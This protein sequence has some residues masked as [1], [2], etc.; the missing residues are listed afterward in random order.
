[1]KNVLRTEELAKVLLKRDNISVMGEDIKDYYHNRS[2]LVTGGGGSVGR[3]ICLSLAKCRPS[4]IVIFDIYENNAFML[5]QK[6]SRLYGNSVEVCV[7]I[8]SVQ[9]KDRL[10]TLFNKYDFDVVFHAAAH[11]HVPL[12][13]TNAA[14]AVKNNV[15]GTYILADM[16]EKHHCE[17]FVLI[18]TDKAINPSSVMGATKRL[19]E[20][21]TSCRY[22]S[23]TSFSSVRF[24][25]VF[26]SDGSVI[27][28]F[29]CQM[30]EGGPLLIT[31]KRM[32]RYFMTITEAS[33][34]LMAAGA[35]ASK[36]E[37]YVLNTGEKINMYE[38]AKEL[39]K[40]EGLEPDKDIEIK[41]TGFRPG[42]KLVEEL[43]L[44]ENLVSTQNELIYIEKE[45]P[46]TREAVDE[47]ML[48]L[49]DA[50]ETRDNSAIKK[51]LTA[52]VPT[53]KPLQI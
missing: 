7:E 51:A 12:M 2:V 48:V 9:D 3:E 28:L 34:L 10:E 35:M 6:L 25:N 21:I 52:V 47:K 11:K 1:M 44:G 31:D 26:A 17:R 16:A 19:C 27:P 38:M 20:L 41:E 23:V 36:G 13:E 42:E 5:S 30:E 46:L 29:R 15:F 45:K 4:R 14:Q 39:I 53:Y 49:R 24:C 40:A 8:G 22:D 43:F 50:V 33:Q 18:S 32:C 37:I